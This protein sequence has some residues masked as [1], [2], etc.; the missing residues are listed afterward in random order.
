MKRIKFPKIKDVTILLYLV[1]LTSFFILVIFI[2]LPQTERIFSNQRYDLHLGDTQLWSKEFTIELKID[3][4]DLTKKWSLINKTKNILQTRLSKIGVSDVIYR[5]EQTDETTGNLFVKIVT[6][7]PLSTVETII[8]SAIDIK[9]MVKKDDV[10]FDTQTDPYSQFNPENYT[11]SSI[12]RKDF[13]TIYI[14]KLKTTSDGYAYFGIF[15]PWVWNNSKIFNFFAQNSG[16][17]GGIYTDGFVTPIQIPVYVAG[18]ASSNTAKPFLSMGVG[19]DKNTADLQNVLFNSG[20][21]PLTYTFKESKVID[22]TTQN[23][24]VMKFSILILGVLIIGYILFSTLLLKMEI[25]NVISFFITL[26]VFIDYLKLSD[27]KLLLFNLLTLVLF[28]FTLSI[29][30]LSKKYNYAILVSLFIFFGILYLIKIG[31]LYSL[32]PYLLFIIVVFVT[33]TFVVNSYTKLFR[34]YISK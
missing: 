2:S 32:V 25:N 3:A 15:K 4:K 11:E 23:I 1:L 18:N 30:N 9:I 16:K 22:V 27:T 24:D 29:I 31:W 8:Q 7:K 14:T 34:S 5:F 10:T 21:F 6:D 12:T 19:I 17:D 26:A 28:G 33:V 13:R 20:S